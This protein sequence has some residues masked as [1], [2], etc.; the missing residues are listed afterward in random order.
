MVGVI[1]EF[2][3]DFKASAYVPSVHVPRFGENV[4]T[5]AGSSGYG[6]S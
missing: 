1:F 4:L 6:G 3:S 2:S 5:Q